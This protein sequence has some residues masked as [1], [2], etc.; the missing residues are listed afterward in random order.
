[1]AYLCELTVLFGCFLL[2]CLCLNGYLSISICPLVGLRS[3]ALD[4]AGYIH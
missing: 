2:L 4:C 1:M 3:K